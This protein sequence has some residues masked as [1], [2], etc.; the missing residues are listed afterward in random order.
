M[1][2]EK[3]LT[4]ECKPGVYCAEDEGQDIMMNYCVV[5]K[6]PLTEEIR[7]L[8]ARLECKWTVTRCQANDEWWCETHDVSVAYNG[9]K[10]PE[11]PCWKIVQ[12]ERDESDNKLLDFDA[13]L[14][15]AEAR[16]KELEIELGKSRL[17]VEGY[18]DRGRELIEERDTLKARLEQKETDWLAVADRLREERDLARAEVESLFK[19]LTRWQ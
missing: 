16:V 6:K 14:Y 18:S 5:H 1:S 2:D 8:R 17:A 12:R 15:K 4:E 3:P 19:E 11:Q 7:S 9:E 13:K 10:P